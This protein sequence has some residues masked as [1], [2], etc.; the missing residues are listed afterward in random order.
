MI[1]QMI[2]WILLVMFLCLLILLK[3]LLLLL[4]NIF[5]ILRLGKLL[6]LTIFS[7]LFYLKLLN[8]LFFIIILITDFL[9]INF[10]IQRE[11]LIAS[12]LC[13]NLY[14]FVSV[15]W[16]LLLIFIGCGIRCFSLQI[17]FKLLIFAFLGQIHGQPFISLLLIISLLQ[18]FSWFF[19]NADILRLTLCCGNWSYYRT[20]ICIN[21]CILRLWF[22]FFFFIC[23]LNELLLICKIFY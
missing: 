14:L 7:L 20:Y 2:L 22:I 13:W 6:I 23:K 21:I 11:I 19:N 8:F 15:K 5:S 10:N 17:F 1:F 9:L 12:C 3:I 18:I 16:N 4:W